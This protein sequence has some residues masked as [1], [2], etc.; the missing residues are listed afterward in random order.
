MEET[1]KALDTLVARLLSR[2]GLAVIV[3]VV[4]EL[5]NEMSPTVAAPLLAI[6]L[7]RSAVKAADR[8]KSKSGDETDTAA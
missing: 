2:E 4:M 8:F 3:A 5:A 7:G 6:I 1:K